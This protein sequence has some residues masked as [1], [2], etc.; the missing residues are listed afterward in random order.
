MIEKSD[1]INICGDLTIFSIISS[2]DKLTNG[3]MTV[4]GDITQVGSDYSNFNQSGDFILKIIGEN[5]SK[6]KI[7]SYK[8][9]IFNVLDLTEGT[10]AILS[11]PIRINKLSGDY[12]F[13]DKAIIEN[14]NLTLDDYVYIGGNVEFI[15]FNVDSTGLSTNGII[16]NK[17][18]LFSTYILAPSARKAILNGAKFENL[19]FKCIETES[20]KYAK[21]CSNCKETFKDC[22]D[23]GDE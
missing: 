9:S 14:S 13:I 1:E 16:S 23:I 8:L 11:T 18:K 19:S 4:Q 2:Q 6:I 10:G 17:R 21:P 15:N 3:V 5:T 7:D 20:G 22:I 12:K